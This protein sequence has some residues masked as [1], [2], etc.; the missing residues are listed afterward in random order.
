MGRHA[1]RMTSHGTT[2]RPPHGMSHGWQKSSHGRV[3]GRP[4]GRPMGK[5]L[6][7][8]QTFHGML[9][10]CPIQDEVKPQRASHGTAHGRS[11]GWHIIPVGLLTG[12]LSH[13]QHF[14][15]SDVLWNDIKRMERPVGLPRGRNTVPWI[16]APWVVPYA[17][18]WDFSW[19][20]CRPTNIP[21]TPHNSSHIRSPSD[22]VL[23]MGRPTWVIQ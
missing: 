2:H 6:P 7:V 18:P 17:I 4:M 16:I 3:M 8:G 23:P 21:F 19:G 20:A 13:G 22:D 14:F 10:V 1:A 12:Y 5:K 15:P 9:V 11:S